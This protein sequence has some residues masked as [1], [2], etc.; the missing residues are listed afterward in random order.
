MTK[1]KDAF[2]LGVEYIV[3]FL[4]L[5]MVFLFIVPQCDVFFF[6]QDTLPEWDS[7][8]EYSLNY[9]NGRFLG[10]FI[11]AFLS[12]H[13]EYAWLACAVCMFITIISANKLFFRNS[14]YA[15]F[16]LA[17]AIVFISSGV[18]SECYTLFASFV[19]YLVP[20]TV[21]LVSLCIYDKNRN[22]QKG[23]KET[24]FLNLLMF[25]LTAS[26]CLYSENTTIVLVV[27]SILLNLETI[28]K[29][30][31]L[32]L[33]GIV[34]LAGNLVG[35]AIMLMIPVLTETSQK[36]DYYR[37][38]ATSVIG[39][40]TYVPK[41][42]LNFAEVF[43]SST[44]L[45][46]GLSLVLVVYALGQK[47][48]SKVRFACISFFSAY[49]FVTVL[50]RLFGDQTQSYPIMNIFEAVMA[51]GY[52]SFWLLFVF[53]VMPKEKRLAAVGWT[54]LLL[55]S[56][57]PMMLVNRDGYRTYMTTCFII[58]GMISYLIKEQKLLEIASRFLNKKALV[59]AA[60]TVFA[61]CCLYT[62]IQL[63]G[64]YCFDQERNDYI[65]EKIDEGCE[66][67]KVPVIPF[68]SVSIEDEW[69]GI[70]QQLVLDHDIEIVVTNINSCE[71]AEE[72]NAIINRSFIST[73]QKALVHKIQSM[74]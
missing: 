57:V 29:D 67:A 49:P 42:F 60:A 24:I 10:N 22:S 50:F 69:P 25:C 43:N 31:R 44:L 58:I 71:N 35:T 21:A 33:A 36:L 74:T 9:G 27:L 2:L 32:N 28:L 6:R 45:L 63:A 54:V 8:M 61:F 53:G 46:F 52:F 51:I 65:H 12:H 62:S 19:N 34:F 66:E 23:F 18:F 40:I 70:T 13:F 38:V 5:S 7:L 47:T 26:A 68:V 11:G 4:C 30:K 64:N 59:F 72:Y 39:I 17:L 73:F 3:L 56:I 37:S 48:D 55:S 20:I 15:V 41:R 16:P 14:V 1:R